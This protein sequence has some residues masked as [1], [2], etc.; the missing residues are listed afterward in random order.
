MCGLCVE[1]VLAKNKIIGTAVT[2]KNMER[3]MGFTNRSEEPH[4]KFFV[5]KFQAS[6]EV[7]PL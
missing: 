5:D 7:K 3:D 1:S 6:F 2:T 4:F